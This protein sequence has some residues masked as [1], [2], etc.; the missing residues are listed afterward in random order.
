[1]GRAGDPQV[2][3]TDLTVWDR[4]LTHDQLPSASVQKIDEGTTLPTNK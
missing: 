1:M 4:F 2:L 3:Q